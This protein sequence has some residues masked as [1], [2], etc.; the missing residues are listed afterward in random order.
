MGNAA[1]GQFD[2]GKQFSNRNANIAR[3]YVWERSQIVME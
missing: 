1:C 2:E 3:F